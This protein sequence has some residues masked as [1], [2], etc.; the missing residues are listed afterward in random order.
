LFFF[1]LLVRASWFC[2]RIID[3]DLLRLQ[4]KG[5]FCLVKIETDGLL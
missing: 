1:S 5:A 3:E 4:N 2:W